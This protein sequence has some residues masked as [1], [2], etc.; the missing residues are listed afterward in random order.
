METVL[1]AFVVV[2]VIVFAA[3]SLSAAVITSQEALSAAQSEADARLAEQGRTALQVV[4]ARTVANRT[5]IELTLRNSGSTRL[6]EFDRWDVIVRSTGEVGS[7]PLITY[8]YPA[9]AL[10][11]GAAYED[12]RDALSGATWAAGLFADAQAEMDELAQPDI[13]NAGEEII[14]WARAPH[15]IAPGSAIEVALA[16]E[17]GAG[18]FT[19][20]RANIPPVLVAH[21]LVVG[22]AQTQVTLG[23]EHWQAMDQD[24]P[25]EALVYEVSDESVRPGALS[26]ATF[27][28]ADLDAGAVVY[29]RAPDTDSETIA[30]SLSDG[31]DTLDGLAFT[32]MVNEPPVYSPETD[33]ILLSDGEAVPLGCLNTTDPDNGPEAITFTL[34]APPAAGALH[35]AG[36]PLGVG[37]RFTLADV[38]AGALT[39]AGNAPDSFRFTVSDDYNPGG[40]E[41]TV[42]ITTPEG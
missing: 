23:R 1:A 34:T 29:T 20:F 31:K 9:P 4:G 11:P 3:L 16:T 32:V 8:L 41:Y 19:S 7:A 38:A 10:A 18:I 33:T 6:A 5:L 13:L 24:D 35:L 42:R 12:A 26:A 22:R 25:A 17:Y 30:F 28:Q 14:V 27:S 36:A 40:E 37:A 15:V 2:F 39:F 21:G